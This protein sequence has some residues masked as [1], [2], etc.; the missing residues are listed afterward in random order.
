MENLNTFQERLS[1]VILKYFQNTDSIAAKK[2]GVNQSTISRWQKSE[3]QSVN[4]DI[5]KRFE[6]YGISLRWLQHGLGEMEIKKE[7]VQNAEILEQSITAEEYYRKIPFITVP[8]NAGLGY[9]LAD[10]EESVVRERITAYPESCKKLRIIGDS[11]HP[12]KS[13]STAVFDEA[14]QPTNG[15]LCVAIVDGVLYFKEYREEDG[16]IFL[17]STNPNYEPIKLNGFRNWKILGKV[18]E[19]YYKY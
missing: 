4:W 11:M 6:K 2:I 12:I 3:N 16:H 14:K 17:Y 5:V 18:E 19:V 9:T 7:L 15:D 1:Y 10:E 8:A 13:G